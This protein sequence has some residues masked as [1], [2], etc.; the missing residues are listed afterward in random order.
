VLDL[1]EEKLAYGPIMVRL[2]PKRYAE[3]LAANPELGAD[4]V[5]EYALA[6]LPEAQLGLGHMLLDGHGMTRDPEAAFRWFGHA[7]RQGN[8]DAWNMLGRCYE[9]GWGVPVDREVAAQWYGLAAAKSHAW[10]QFNL[11]ALMLGR[12]GD[13]ADL[14]R[15]LSLLVASARAGN[16]KAMNLVGQFREKGWMRPPKLHAA[17]LWFRLSAQGGCFRGQFHH[18]RLLIQE[19]KVT[20]AIR[21]LRSSLTQGPEDFAREAAEMLARHPE[22]RVARLATDLLHVQNARV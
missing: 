9:C 19:G 6:G 2:N 7:A 5:R 16:P 4:F 17:K 12:D 11:A 20:E 15:A 21:W 10:A 22:P 8:V 3:R 1:T 14:A 18:A 13:E